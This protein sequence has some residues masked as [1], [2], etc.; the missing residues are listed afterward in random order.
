[1]RDPGL[2]QALLGRGPGH[3]APVAE[4]DHELLVGLLGPGGQH[5]L[6]AVRGRGH[7]DVGRR[8]AARLGVVHLARQR[9][10]DL[11]LAVVF[12]AR[13][14]GHETHGKPFNQPR[15]P[16]LDRHRP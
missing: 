16:P 1:V 5:R 14:V 6:V 13:I 10:G 4:V 12:L 9:H 3:L 2:A 15:P 7:L 8:L 11:Q